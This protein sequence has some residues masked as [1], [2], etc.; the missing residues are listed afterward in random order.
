VGFDGATCLGDFRLPD[1]WDSGFSNVSLLIS[2]TL[3]IIFNVGSMSSLTVENKYPCSFGPWIF[4]YSWT[5][6]TTVSLPDFAVEPLN[7]DSSFKC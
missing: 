4:R 3:S 7:L 1:M 5:H 6:G 2:V